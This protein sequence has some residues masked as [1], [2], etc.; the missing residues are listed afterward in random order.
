MCFEAASASSLAGAVVVL[1]REGKI[2]ATSLRGAQATKQSSFVSF[3]QSWIAS[4][5]LS[6]GAHSRDPVARNDDLAEAHL[7]TSSVPIWRY[8]RMSYRGTD[9]AL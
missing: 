9:T 8:A 4:R 7:A 6:S 2:P 1:G 3:N 5:S